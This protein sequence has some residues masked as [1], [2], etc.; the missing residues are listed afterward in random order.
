MRTNLVLE[1]QDVPGQLVGVLDPIGALGANIVTIIHQ[2]DV[3]TERGTIPVEI[4]L[5]GDQETLDRVLNKLDELN[6][7]IRA[8][9]G[10]MLKEKIITLLLGKIIDR[11]VKDTMDKINQLE[12]VRVADLELK[13]SEN[14]QDSSAKIIV[15]AEYGNRDLFMDKINEIADFKGFQV[16]SEV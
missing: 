14:D 1:L 6:I 16:I 15:E 4:T 2:R 13:I 9:D 5:E 7:H 8:V 11:D 12:G 3:K 10:I